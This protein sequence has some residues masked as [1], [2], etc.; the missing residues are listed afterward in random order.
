MGEYKAFTDKNAP[1]YQSIPDKKQFTSQMVRSLLEEEGGCRFVQCQK[2]GKEKEYFLYNTESTEGFEKVREKVRQGMMDFLRKEK[3]NIAGSVVVTDAS[4]ADSSKSSEHIN[5]DVLE[6]L[7]NVIDSDNE[8]HVA[9]VTM[10]DANDT[11]DNGDRLPFNL[12][13]DALVYPEDERPPSEGVNNQKILCC[14]CDKLKNG[15]T[16]FKCMDDLPC[17]THGECFWCRNLNRE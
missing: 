4:T 1:K 3:D 11:P 8:A 6:I 9:D 12:K 10:T 14:G 13:R 15:W 5:E 17:C 16:C 2:K 7:E